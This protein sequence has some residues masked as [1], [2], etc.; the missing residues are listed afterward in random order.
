MIRNIDEKG[1]IELSKMFFRLLFDLLIDEV[2]KLSNF[3]KNYFIDEFSQVENLMILRR[4]INSGK[5]K[6][7][8]NVFTIKKK[9]YAASGIID[10]PL[11][12]PQGFTEYTNDYRNILPQHI[13]VCSIKKGTLV[14]TNCT[15]SR[16]VNGKP[17]INVG[18]DSAGKDCNIVADLNV[19]HLNSIN[20]IDKLNEI[21]KRVV[22][23][24]EIVKNEF[25]ESTP[26]T[27]MVETY[28]I[29]GQ[30][31][32]RQ[33]YAFDCSVD[34]KEELIK[35]LDQFAMDVV[36]RINTLKNEKKE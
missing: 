23:L 24:Q 35:K 28:R 17:T 9:Y 5:H 11:L 29:I 36:E 21:K 12:P 31:V 27:N 1:H 25:S 14:E 7:H 33:G 13:T 22:S 20:D 16:Y 4:F 2:L 34:G 19:C 15:H 18:H 8:D 32:N 30:E 10:E 3:L 6:R 26:S